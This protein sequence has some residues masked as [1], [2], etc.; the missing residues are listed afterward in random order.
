MKEPSVSKRTL[1]EC[2]KKKATEGSAPAVIAVCCCSVILS[3]QYLRP[4]INPTKF[5]S[6]LFC[7]TLLLFWIAFINSNSSTALLLTFSENARET[8]LICS[9]KTLPYPALLPPL[10]QEHC[11]S[12]EEFD[13]LTFQHLPLHVSVFPL[14]L[15]QSHSKK[16]NTRKGEVLYVLMKGWLGIDC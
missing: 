12:W 8:D 3:C 16:K 7:V 11:F 13:F 9:S 1:S 14:T 5:S 10:L 4:K 2:K 6:M 15:L